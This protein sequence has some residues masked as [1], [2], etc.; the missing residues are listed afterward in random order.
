M[1]RTNLRLDLAWTAH[2]DHMR[3]FDPGSSPRTR[4]VTSKDD[5]KKE[6]TGHKGGESDVTST[7]STALSETHQE[8]ELDAFFFNTEP[9]PETFD[10]VQ[11]TSPTDE[12]GEPQDSMGSG[13]GATA[14]T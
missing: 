13:G 11:V 6:G 1:S 10:T 12:S 7:A 3:L 14:D 8:M 2:T 4:L 9:L 5:A